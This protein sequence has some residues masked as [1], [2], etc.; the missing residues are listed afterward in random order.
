MQNDTPPLRAGDNCWRKSHV[1]RGGILLS[2]RD[3]F[4]AFRRAV[5]RAESEILIL[6]WDISQQVE[7]IR[8]D[9]L[10]DG[11]PRELADFLFAV[12][13]DKPGLSI[14]ILLWDYS[15]LYLTEREWL[16]FS[17]WRNPGHPRLH[18]VT[19][20]AIDPG[21][22]H[23]QKLVVIDGAL[24]FCGGIDLSLWRW[25]SGRHLPDDSRRSNSRQDHYQPYHDL[26]LV[27]TGPVVGDLRELAAMRWKRAGAGELPGVT[28]PADPPAW[29]EG[30]GVAFED[31]PVA[32]ALTFSRYRNHEPSR[33]I[34]RLHLEIIE[35]T[36]QCLYIENQYLSSHAIVAA[37]AK[38]LGEADGPEVVLVLTRKAGW[39]EEKTLGI[40]RDRLIEILEQ[41]D[42]HGRFSCCFPHAEDD[43]GNESQIYVHAKLLI[44]D[45]RMLLTGSAN[46]SNRSMKVDSELDLAFLHDEPQDFIRTLRT[47]LLAMHFGVDRETI[48]R[49]TADAGSLG[50][51]IIALR[52]KGGN[53]LRVLRGGCNSRLERKL[54]D[55]HLL[56]PDEPI[57]P[58]HHLREALRDRRELNHRARAVPSL[59]TWLKVGA[60]VTALVAVGL[61][62]SR[63][64]STHVDRERVVAL[65]EPIRDSPLALPL[66]TLVVTLAG[67]VGLPLNLFIIASA[68]TFGPWTAFGCGLFGAMI[69]A[70]IS[71][72]I[73][74]HFG[75]P[76]ARRVAGEK[77][78]SLATTMADRGIGSVAILRVLPIAPFGIMNLVAGI[79]GLRFSVFMI[80]SAIGLVPG[81]AAVTFATGRFLEAIRNPSPTAWLVFSLTL[82]AIAG[83]ALWL[84]RKIR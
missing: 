14:R 27:L 61:A 23:H 67:I 32:L 40:L 37:L 75:K 47:G 56:D 33:H 60:W 21:A 50:S 5:L 38:R 55:T 79:S 74:H 41:A 70:A 43:Q 81:I 49:E 65:L 51:A 62:I 35:A 26:Q 9:E 39:A 3:Y 12:L 42:E 73:G 1:A 82:A 54:A 64:W 17:R 72:A 84:R 25:D 20:D 24:A 4:L 45:D 15:V 11:Y 58:A 78:E 34:E 59:R 52:R 13:G 2:T 30:V 7:L 68:V 46:L 66:L 44:A 80:G 36:R 8:E 76:L 10:D 83:T 48:E 31:E 77:L 29:P 18:L 57:G 69:A 19:D 71:F 6:A 22:S 16:P 53:R 28:E 63:L